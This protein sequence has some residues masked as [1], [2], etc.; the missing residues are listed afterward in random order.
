[1]Q[2]FLLTSILR[3]RFLKKQKANKML[4][5]FFRVSLAKK[6]VRKLRTE[7]KEKERRR[8]ME[9]FTRVYKD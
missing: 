5:C 4:Q 7:G 1:M 2:K 6:K 8:R 3:K 9:I